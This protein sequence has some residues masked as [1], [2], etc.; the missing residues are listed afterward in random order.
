MIKNNEH[1]AIVF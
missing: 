1:N